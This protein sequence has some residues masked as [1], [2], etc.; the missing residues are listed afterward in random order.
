MSKEDDIRR[1]LQPMIDRGVVHSVGMGGRPLTQPGGPVLQTEP[2]A[3]DVNGRLGVDP[4]SYRP[5]IDDLLQKAG[6]TDVTYTIRPRPP[7][8]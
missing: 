2:I 4:E 6:I 7:S 1:A 5:E 8:E 3:I